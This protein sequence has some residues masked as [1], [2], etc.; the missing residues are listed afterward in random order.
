M[1]SLSKALTK[2]ANT[3]TEDRGSEGRVGGGWGCESGG[4]DAIGNS[5]ANNDTHNND[6][7]SSSSS[8][9]TTTTNNNDNNDNDNTNNSDDIIMILLGQRRDRSTK[10][11]DTTIQY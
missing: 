9:T 2:I 11:P 4:S 7:D 8:T 6:N 3:G 1:P 10:I 5:T